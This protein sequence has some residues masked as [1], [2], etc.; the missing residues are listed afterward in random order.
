[1]V[2]LHLRGLLLSHLSPDDFQI[3]CMNYFNQTLAK[4]EYK[5]GRI[6]DNKMAA[7]MATSCRFALVYTLI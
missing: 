1:M 7:K 6:N 2:S 5:F 4:S 3:S